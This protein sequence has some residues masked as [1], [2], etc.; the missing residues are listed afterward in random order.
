MPS[1]TSWNY[2]LFLAGVPPIIFKKREGS[3]VTSG[4][5]V[6]GQEIGQVETEELLGEDEPSESTSKKPGYSI[7]SKLFWYLNL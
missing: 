4:Q 5:A 7:Q 6:E 1:S 3:G 2:G